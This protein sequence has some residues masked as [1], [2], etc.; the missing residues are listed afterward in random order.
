MTFSSLGTSGLAKFGPPGLYRASRRGRGF[1][2]QPLLG[3]LLGIVPASTS[4][5]CSVTGLLL[6]GL[7]LREAL[8]LLKAAFTSCTLLTYK[9]D[10]RSS[11]DCSV[12]ACTQD[13]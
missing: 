5:G 13:V 2:G 10:L 3:S 7:L 9:Q 8:R 12:P 1:A 11:E 6:V 4:Y